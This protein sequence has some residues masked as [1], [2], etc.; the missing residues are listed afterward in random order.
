MVVG[1]WPRKTRER[2][3][4]DLLSL[5]LRAIP[6]SS[7]ADDSL[8]K[9]VLDSTRRRLRQTFRALVSSEGQKDT[10]RTYGTLF[11]VL[12]SHRWVAS[13]VAG[14]R[15][16]SQ[17]PKECRVGKWRERGRAKIRAK[18]EPRA[19]ERDERAVERG[20]RKKPE[21]ERSTSPCCLG[22]WQ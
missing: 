22:H 19:K 5:L 2:C 7:K 11:L 4:H 17:S 1:K 15:A 21:G 12:G 6:Y 18:S 13:L 20:G 8:Q 10:P 16:G 14:S 9:P 3:M